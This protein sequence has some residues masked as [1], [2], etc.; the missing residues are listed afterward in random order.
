LQLSVLLVQF[1]T[2]LIQLPLAIYLLAFP[3]LA[4]RL[5]LITQLL[6]LPPAGLQFLFD[7]GEV[8]LLLRGLLVQIRMLHIQYFGPRLQL[9]LKFL[10]RFFSGQQFFLVLQQLCLLPFYFICCL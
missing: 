9:L 7:V 6:Q 10:Q 5:Q 3:R 1:F 2:T 8:C 4:L